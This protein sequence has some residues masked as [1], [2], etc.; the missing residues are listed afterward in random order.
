MIVAMIVPSLDA[1][2][3]TKAIHGKLLFN[4]RYW[5][6]FDEAHR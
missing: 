1:K 4:R 5:P 2:K 6:A 3:L